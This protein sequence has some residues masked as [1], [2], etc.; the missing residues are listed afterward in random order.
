MMAG[1]QAKMKLRIQVNGSE[2]V[3]DVVRQGDY[4]VI[5]R[6]GDSTRLRLLR[7]EAHDLVLEVEADAG[8]P[9]Y[10]RRL[11]QAA[12]VALDG[13]RRQ[14]WLEGRVVTYERMPARAAARVEPGEAADL[15]ASIPAIVSQ[16]LV[17]PGDSVVAGDKLLLLE[18]MKMV[19]PIQAPYAGKVTAIHCEAGQAVE[20]GFALLEVEPVG[21]ES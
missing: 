14:L 19:I 20:P 21:E 8:Q 2:T 5:T 3:V 6:D 18:S 12:G 1:D 4:L 15:A 11:I 9:S 16:V 7:E 13:T 17:K 10:P